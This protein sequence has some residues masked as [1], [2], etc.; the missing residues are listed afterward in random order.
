LAAEA[1]RRWVEF[2]K[3]AL[4][5]TPSWGRMSADTILTKLRK[6]DARRNYDRI[7][8]QILSSEKEFGRFVSALLDETEEPQPLSDGP[9]RLGLLRSGMAIGMRLAGSTF[10]EDA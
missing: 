2:H 8:V 1:V 10:G 6:L 3:E 4:G 7:A 5:F 9:G